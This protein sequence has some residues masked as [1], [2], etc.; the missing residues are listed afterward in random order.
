MM[1]WNQCMKHMRVG[2]KMTD[3]F[4]HNEKEVKFPKV[5]KIMQQYYANGLLD[6][7]FAIEKEIKK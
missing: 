6:L 4:K 7:Y 3:E 1:E 2:V 5:L